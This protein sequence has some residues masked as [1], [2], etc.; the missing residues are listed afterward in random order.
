MLRCAGYKHSY[1]LT[2]SIEADVNYKVQTVLAGAL[3]VT[4]DIH[5]ITDML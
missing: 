4:A 2:L 3:A 5:H 1:S